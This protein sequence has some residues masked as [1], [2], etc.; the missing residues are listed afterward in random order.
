[1]RGVVS[2]RWHKL[3]ALEGIEALNLEPAGND[4]NIESV[5]LNRKNLAQLH[6]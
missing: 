6:L 3:D 1:M 4:E 5:I 2:G